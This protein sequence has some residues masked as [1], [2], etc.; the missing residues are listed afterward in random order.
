[1]VQKQGYSRLLIAPPTPP[2]PHLPHPLPHPIP[3]RRLG[4]VRWGGVG[5]QG[6]DHLEGLGGRSGLTRSADQGEPYRVRPSAGSAQADATAA[7]HLGGGGWGEPPFAWPHTTPHLAHP[8]PPHP[9]LPN[10]RVGKRVGKVGT[11]WGRWGNKQRPNRPSR[12]LEMWSAAGMN[13]S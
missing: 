12:H 9:T 6:F 5:W 7:R 2:A 4:G 8:T 11:G 13:S 1:M 10:L 3:T